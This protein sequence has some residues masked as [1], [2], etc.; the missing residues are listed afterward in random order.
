MAATLI[1]LQTSITKGDYISRIKQLAKDSQVPWPETYSP[2]TNTIA[3][4]KVAFRDIETISSLAALQSLG[5]R[6]NQKTD[7]VIVIK[8][9][10]PDWI[11]TIGT[12][13][14][15]DPAFFVEHARNPS[16]AQHWTTQWEHVFSD[17][18][19]VQPQPKEWYCLNGTYT[20]HE[21][22]AL[23]E[24]RHQ[25]PMFFPRVRTYRQAKYHENLGFQGKD[26]V[27]VRTR[28]SYV[29]AD[30]HTYIILIDDILHNGDPEAQLGALSRTTLRM[31]YANNRGGGIVV[32]SL[33]SQSDF[34][35]LTSFVSFLEHGWHLEVL[36]GLT[37]ALPIQPFLYL[38]VNSLWQ[39]NLTFVDR[40][41]KEV[42][43]TEIRSP[44]DRT[45]QKLHDL[46]ESIAN[47]RTR[48]SETQL[49]MSSSLDAYYDTFGKIKNRHYKT[50]HSPSDNFGEILESAD[51]LDRF[52]M[53]TFQLL[54]STLSVRDSQISIR[55]SRRGMLLTVLA[56]IYV[57][58]SFITGIFG[59]N[60]K[61][62][63]G[64]PLSIW[65]CF[66]ALGVVI[67]MTALGFLSYRY[68]YRPGMIRRR[69]T[70]ERKVMMPVSGSEKR[71]AV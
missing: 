16:A 3:I 33:Y 61:E 64:S 17:E 63:N 56:F 36:F 62:I 6:D 67:A 68:W 11:E 23:T 42:S 5:Q 66:V 47:I 52:L 15:L 10:T 32:P 35:L 57:P 53:E 43:F 31:P 21:L 27:Q 12:K 41:L 58:L 49:H 51:K 40:K 37:Q 44:N 70:W 69:E 54:M 48:V 20:C 24:T 30:A 26:A 13:Y 14:S 60:V 1:T 25:R 2:S 7:K 18:K 46:R 8:N 45:A 39:T 19:T 65:V 38:F 59:M 71:P 55:Q 28:L 4:V 22:K 34:S 9:V 29:R 50:Y